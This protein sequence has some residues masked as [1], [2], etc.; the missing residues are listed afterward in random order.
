MFATRRC[1]FLGGVCGLLHSRSFD[2]PPSLLPINR[3]TLFQLMMAVEYLHSIGVAHRDIKLENVLLSDDGQRIKVTDFGLAARLDEWEGGTKQKRRAWG[4]PKRKQRR[5]RTACG[6]PAY[7]AP[8]VIDSSDEQR[9]VR[10][11]NDTSE[12]NHPSR[13]MGSLPFDSSR[14]PFLV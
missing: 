12:Q 4:G 11:Y 1:V 3:N 2:P 5:Q 14:E 9:C 6:T 10:E 8:E 7:A 13:M